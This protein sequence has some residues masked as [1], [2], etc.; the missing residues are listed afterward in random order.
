MLV[1]R[2]SVSVYRVETED[3]KQYLIHENFRIRFKNLFQ[4]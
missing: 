4:S 1:E 3:V 2:K